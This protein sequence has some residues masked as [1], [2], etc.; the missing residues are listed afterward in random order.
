MICRIQVPPRTNRSGRELCSD[1]IRQGVGDCDD[2]FVRHSRR[3][4]QGER[5]RGNSLSDREVALAESE[6]LAI[7]RLEVERAEVRAARNPKRLELF[8]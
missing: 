8:D 1:S 4:G 3:E 5:R 2:V 7:E 6:R